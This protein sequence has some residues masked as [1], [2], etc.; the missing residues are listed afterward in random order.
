M[1][2]HIAN[3]YMISSDNNNYYCDEE[4]RA[5]L[6]SCMWNDDADSLDQH[7]AYLVGTT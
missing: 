7:L 4:R 3:L 2:E 1:G 6:Y 5:D